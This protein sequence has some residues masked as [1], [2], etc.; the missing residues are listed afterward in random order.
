MAFSTLPGGSGDDVYHV[1]SSTQKVVEYF[2]GGYDTVIASVSFDAGSQEIEVLSASAKSTGLHL[3]G[4]QYTQEI[5]GSMGQDV[6]SDGGHHDAMITMAGGL[7][8]D[9]YIVSSYDDVI[10]E[11][12][13]A[14]NGFDT[15]QTDLCAYELACNVEVLRYS[16]SGSFEGYGNELNNAIYGGAG[17]DTLDGGG[18]TDRLVGGAGNDVYYI[19]DLTDFVVEAADGG[20]DVMFAQ[21]MMAKAAPNVEVLIFQGEGAFT[22]FANDQGTILIGSYSDDTLIGGA[23]TD[24]LYGSWGANKLTGGGGSDVFVFDNKWSEN[25]RVT[26]FQH[27][28]DLITISQDD[29]GV[30]HLGASVNEAMIAYDNGVLFYDPTGSADT[31]DRVVIAT[32]DGRP[33]VTNSDFLFI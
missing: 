10:V 2:G 18:G 24:V 1:D 16:G 26:D 33:T 9:T 17:D 21:T 25:N 23:S 30:D 15:I 22:G 31:S 13:G 20:F 5:W 8:N 11:Q 7:G 4:N 27:G 3:T 29:Y 19:N 6:L 14:S 32:F 28:I 12:A